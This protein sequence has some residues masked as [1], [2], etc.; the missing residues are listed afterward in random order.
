VVAFN[1]TYKANDETTT[2]ASS[3]PLAVA[4]GTGCNGLQAPG[5]QGTYYAQVIYAAQAAL[6]AQQTANPGS[7]N[8]MIILSD[9]D[10]NACS[11]Q[12]NTASGGNN[13]CSS[14]SQIVAWN[15]PNNNFGGS[16][17]N[18]SA[19]NGTCPTSTTCS[20]NTGYNSPSYPSELG[21]CGQA[22]Q[23]AQ[24][25]TTAGTMVY[26]V[27]MGSETSGGC[28]TDQTKTLTNLSNGAVTWPTG[29]SY[30]KQPC[31][32]IAAMASTANTFYSDNTGGCAATNN[33]AFTTMSSIFQAILNGLTSARLI[34]N[35]T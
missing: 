9:G 32:A 8:I 31:N 23:A 7:K 5:G 27:A 29:G 20:T 13:S 16:G 14:A 22:V 34:P 18:G 4:V 3:D 17:C 28:T 26:T 19:L 1:D 30:P 25:A 6:V 35:G 2:L 24:S 12:A 11:E 21:Q 15:C 10:A 33:S